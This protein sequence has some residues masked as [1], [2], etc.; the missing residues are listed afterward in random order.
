MVKDS[1]L[2]PQT[3]EDPEAVHGTSTDYRSGSL[4]AFTSLDLIAVGASGCNVVVSVLSYWSSYCA[5]YL[6]T[7]YDIKL[8]V[9]TC[10][11]WEIPADIDIVCTLE[12]IKSKYQTWLVYSAE[13]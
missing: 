3:A 4:I 13:R 12:P 7:F 8:S 6:I 2:L 5:S 11:S 9:L 10:P 1:F